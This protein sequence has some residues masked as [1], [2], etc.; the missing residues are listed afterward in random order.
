MQST[1]SWLIKAVIGF[2]FLIATQAFSADTSIRLLS[3]TSTDNSGLYQYLLPMFTD[4][5]GIKVYVVA[6]GTGQ[7]LRAAKNGDGDLLIVHARNAELAF[8]AQGYGSQRMEFMYNDF[9][10]VGPASDPAGIR[11]TAEATAAM[12]EIYNRGAVFVSRGDDSGT[13][14]RELW[15]WQQAGINPDNGTGE[16]YREVGAGMGKTLNI[17]ATLDAYTLVDRGTWLSFRNRQNLQILVQGDGKLFN[18][19]SVIE[20]NA[21]KYP[22]LKIEEAKQLADWLVSIEGQ[23]AINAFK[24]N[25]EQLFSSNF[26]GAE[27][28]SR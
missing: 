27:N 11:G 2:G 18:Q 10:I 4:K 26:S 25:G 12:H 8:M 1:K 24:V 15:L 17:A 5:T 16:Q 6:M 21:E 9:V 13:H 7:A 14:K 19:Y 20:M 28:R 3:T 23:Q 22:H